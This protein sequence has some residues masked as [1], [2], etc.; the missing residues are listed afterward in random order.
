MSLVINTSFI[1]FLHG[2]VYYY[3]GVC[4]CTESMCASLHAC[5]CVLT[6]TCYNQCWKWKHWRS[7][8]CCRS[9]SLFKDCVCVCE[10]IERECARVCVCVCVCV[11]VWTDRESVCACVC[12][13]ACV[14]VCVFQHWGVKLSVEDKALKLLQML[15]KSCHLCA[16]TTAQ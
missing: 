2:V 14:H 12:V 8:K 15:S 9:L 5:V 13:W 11:C 16:V 1:T 7:Y 4:V 10:Q 6:L 3:P